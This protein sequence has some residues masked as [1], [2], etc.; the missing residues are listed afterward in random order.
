MRRL[1][2]VTALL[3]ASGAALA[4]PASPGQTLDWR[5]GE[6]CSAQRGPGFLVRIDGMKDRTGRLMV[7]LYP[8]AN[9]DFLKDDDQLQREGKVFRRVT[10]VPARRGPVTLCIDA[11]AA[12]RYALVVI[13]DRDGKRKFDIWK[14][15]IAV[16]GNEHLGRNRPTVDQAAVSTSGGRQ[17]IELHM[18]YMR[19]L[20][21][22]GPVNG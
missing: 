8:A 13:H 12:G 15:G 20:A 17:P 6:N 18:Q 16:P 19:G 7:E 2:I 22:F 10:A 9:E 3:A 11:P 1:A 21:G 14:D 5:R 4:Q